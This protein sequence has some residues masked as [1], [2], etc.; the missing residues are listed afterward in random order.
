MAAVMNALR[1]KLNRL[2][3]MG[4]PE[5]SYR[6][7]QVLKAKLEARGIG[8]ART[9]NPAGACTQATWF[10]KPPSNI[11]PLPYIVAANRIL[12][13]RW[14]VFSLHDI[15]LGFPPIWNR[16]P[17]S[18]CEAPLVFG[19]TLNYRDESLVG[20]IKYLWEPNRHLELVTLAQ[21]YLL[22]GDVR[23]A[24]GCRALLLSWFEQCPYALGPNW[25]SSLEHAV[26]LTN[27]AVAWQ[28]LGG[29]HNPLFAGEAGAE[30]RRLWLESIYL[31]CRFIAGHFSHFSSANN[32]LFGEYMGLFIAALNWPCW[33][34]SARWR[35]QAMI[36]LENE[37]RKQNGPDGVNR[38][39]ATWYHHEVADMM[40]LC[41][42][43]GRASGYDF[44]SR[45]WVRLEAMLTFIA[46][47]MDVAG[48]VPMIGD[49]DDAVMVRFSREPE[50]N[51]YRSLLATGA[52]LF[53]RADFADKAQRYDDKSRWLLGEA[54]SGGFNQ[55]RQSRHERHA[56]RRT[57]S[58]GGYY[59]IGD[60]LDTPEEIRM[61]VDAGPTGYLSIAAHGHA[62][63]LA[64]TL[65][66]GGKEFLIDPGTYAYH[67]EKKWR[68]YFR[69]TSAHNTIRIDTEDQSVSG[70]NFMWLHKA[71]AKCIHWE[72]TDAIQRFAGEHDGYRRLSD[73]VIHRREIEFDSQARSVRITDCIVCRDVHIVEGFWHFSEACAVGRSGHV[74][75]AVNRQQHLHLTLPQ[76]VDEIF[77]TCG[78]EIRPA[79]WVSRAFDVKTPA[80][81]VG[82]KK[83]IEG[84]TCFVTHIKID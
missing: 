32:H 75:S 74:V 51:P 42:L 60:R 33:K 55:L 48:Q 83:R 31:H 1:W 59:L 17:K 73:G 72:S 39:Q 37:A 63:A 57:F 19:K 71:S 79:G 13:G 25:T 41:G 45:Y 52:V 28:L 38:E 68:E 20:D 18:G 6:I 26:R 9:D 82:W 49:A 62:D 24:E 35:D 50:F 12:D 81:T 56:T 5:I 61:M 46:S 40:L 23:Y 10:N 70:G 7:R 53:E 64:V 14:D 77:I 34:E 47:I 21:A 69:G 84:E 16:D 44:S 67:T 8:R 22:S 4:L 80:P 66:V 15:A 3:T 29:E 27:W 58:E 2:Q 54:G 30:F 76:S 36:G 11:S 78:D 65:S 43:L